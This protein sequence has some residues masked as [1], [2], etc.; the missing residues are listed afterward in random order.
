MLRYTLVLL[1]FVGL[2]STSAFN[3]PKSLTSGGVSSFP[4]EMESSHLLPPSSL[5]TGG[6]SLSYTS[7]LE[8]ATTVSL[9]LLWYAL[10]VMYNIINKRVLNRLPH[11]ISIST[12]QL[13]TGSMYYLATLL[14]RGKPK[15]PCPVHAPAKAIY[16]SAFGHM[17]GQ[18]ATVISLEAGAVSFTHIV[19]SLE[20]FFSA[21]F[22]FFSTRKLMDVRVYLSLIPVV[23][24][25]G[26]AC[27][28]KLSYNHLAFLAAMSSNAFFAMRGVKSKYALDNTDLDAPNLFGVVT[29]LSA[30]MAIP[31]AIG[32]EGGALYS[33]L[34]GD[35]DLIKKVIIS[36]LFHYLNNE[37]MYWTLSR[38]TP[39]TL[40]VGNTVKRVFIIAASVIVLGNKVGTKSIVGSGVAI[41]GVM[42]YSLAKMKYA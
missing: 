23:G 37:V 20:P 7:L 3:P 41:S 10:N 42:L 24:G 19:K 31:F 11:P 36:G 6:S 2:V 26:L 12:V 33:G 17:A 4:V 25:V 13:L 34:K 22:T 39:V 35:F 30:I 16:A 14:I 18:T 28:D 38:V 27:L 40:A 9:F 5:P 32:F 15:F 8:P 1:L 29:V 21:V